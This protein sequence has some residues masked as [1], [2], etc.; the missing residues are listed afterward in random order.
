MIIISTSKGDIHLQLDE[1]NTPITAQNF[2]NY[3]R[4]GF[5]N[6]TIFHRVID[7]F[8]IQGGGLTGDMSQKPT[9]T[10]IENEAKS[11]KPNKRGTIAMARTM[12]PHSATAQFFINVA[13]NAFLNFTGEHAQGYGY[14]VFGEV[15][16]GMDVVD[17]IVKVKTGQ[18][19][20]HADVPVEE[21]VIH[22]I[23]EAE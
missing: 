1:V 22:E 18:R 14:C 10:A 12:D 21:I 11:A 9:E 4:S 15:V 17:A 20:G 8:M 5:Y 16:D 13:D 2:L 3:V 6:D 7:G 23:R 19:M